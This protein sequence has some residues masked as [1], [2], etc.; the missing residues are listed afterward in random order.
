[1]LPVIRLLAFIEVPR[2]M[3]LFRIAAYNFCRVVVCLMSTF[4]I[5]SYCVSFGVC[6]ALLLCLGC[7]FQFVHV[8]KIIVL[9]MFLAVVSKLLRNV[10]RVL[11]P[12]AFFAVLTFLHC[13]DI[14]N[15]SF[16]ISASLIQLY[17]QRFSIISWRYWKLFLFPVFS[18]R[19]VYY[20][21][22]KRPMDTVCRLP[23][24]CW[25]FLISCMIVQSYSFKQKIINLPRPINRIF[26]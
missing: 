12:I 24:F 6:G 8:P 22:A 13:V 16:K 25:Q 5:C 10:F 7:I 4:I 3:K 2:Q 9:Q 21:D 11:V 1:M 18:F 20:F 15:R 23:I 17:Q 19:I 14:S 26:V